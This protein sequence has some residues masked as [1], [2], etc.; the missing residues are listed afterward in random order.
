MLRALATNETLRSNRSEM[1]IGTASDMHSNY[2]HLQK[3]PSAG[4]PFHLE[5]DKP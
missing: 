3:P 4:Q 1:Q 2:P 5:K